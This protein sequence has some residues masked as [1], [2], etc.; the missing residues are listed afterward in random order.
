LP[1][2][3]AERLRRVYSGYDQDRREQAKRDPMNPGNLI[4]AAEV[5]SW[6]RRALVQHVPDVAA[7]RVLDAGCGLG[8]LVE[9]LIEAGATPS[10][11]TGADALD[12]RISRARA[13]FPGV[14]F[15]VVDLSSKVPEGPYDVITCFALFSSVLDLRTAQAIAR[16]LTSSLAPGGIVVWYDSRYPNPSNHNVRGWSSAEVRKLFPDLDASLVPVTL[17]PPLARR[18]GFASRTLYPALSALTPLRSH[19]FGVLQKSRPK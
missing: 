9:W 14:R 17:L 8:E 5:R 12:D 16:N 11:V 10:M 13:R 2:I 15:E 1:D 7:A 19:Y 4:R 18:L 6:L 3:E